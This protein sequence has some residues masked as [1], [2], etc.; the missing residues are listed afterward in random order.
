[1]PEIRM[2]KDEIQKLIADA[3]AKGGGQERR[4]SIIPEEVRR[5]LSQLSREEVKNTLGRVMR[6][7]IG[8]GG[9]MQGA[10]RFSAEVLGDAENAP[11]TKLLW[12]GDDP[13][14]GFLVPEEVSSMFIDLL[15]EQ[16]VVLSMGL[17]QV[18]MPAGNLTINGGES[19]PTAFYIGETD[20]ITPSTAKFRQVKLSAKK[21]AGLVPLSNDL[22]R[23]SS[24]QADGI[25]G[26]WLVSTMGLRKDLAFLRGDGT[27]N[28]PLGLAGLAGYSQPITGSTPDDVRN[29][30]SKMK[31]FMRQA[32]IVFNNLGWLMSPRTES[33]LENL[34]DG[35]NGYPYREDI[36]SGKLMGYPS[37]VTTQIPESLGAGG[38]ESELYLVNFGDVV[39]G[40][41]L[42]L[43][44]DTSNSASY[45]EGGTVRSAY[46]NDLTL[47][48]AIEEHDINVFHTE[49]VAMLTAVTW[50]E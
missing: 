5:E 38:N 37:G 41:T 25:V 6:C 36:Q 44:L 10:R 31:L 17:V 3:V 14:G 15:Q 1:M 49:A 27:N 11:V 23:M 39:V 30:L 29:D 43:R 48:R 28:T 18:P 2:T 19:G 33:F 50:G 9:T 35:T 24:P 20:P 7:I 42:A 21:L 13:S 26:N 22:I 8:G 32:N 16:S 4:I 46:Q 34:K 40:N 12:T 45:E 47:I